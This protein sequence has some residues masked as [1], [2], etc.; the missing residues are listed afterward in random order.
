MQK[1][2]ILCLLFATINL[3]A[4][5]PKQV[6]TFPADTVKKAIDY[7]TKELS[8]NHPGFY[9]Y[10]SKQEFDH[11]IDSVKSSL[12]DSLT[13]LDS[14]LKLKPIISKIG[15][16]H[17]G[18][19]LPKGYAE[20]LNQ[21]SNLIPLQVY[22][23]GKKAVVIKNFSGNTA[24]LPK[25]QI[26][27]INGVK[28][29]TIISNLLPLIPSDGYNLTMKYRALYYQ[30]PLWYRLLDPAEEFDLV[31]HKNGIEREY[32]IEG[33]K[34]NDIAESGFLKEPI[35][36]KQ[37]E[38]SVVGNAAILTIHSFANSDIKRVNQNF[39][40]FIKDVFRII[41]RNNLS[42]L[43][44]DLRDNTGGSDGNAVYLTKYFFDTPF[45]YWNRIEVTE[46]IAKQ[47]K[48][49]PLKLFY[50]KPLKK[51]SVWLWQ[52]A[53][54]VN[55]FDFYQPQ[56][57]ARKN[58]KGNTY[59]LIN[60]FC[61]SSCADMAAIL[62]HYKKAVFVGQETGGGY[63]GNTSGMMP[64]MKVDAFDFTISVPL[65]KY[66]NQVDPLKNVGRGTIPDYGVDLTVTDI[67]ERKD[68]ELEFILELIKAKSK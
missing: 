51:D 17:T 64:E 42:N 31:I 44:I 8:L 60:G 2:V 41:K 54:H 36:Q 45:R 52:K 39:K 59:V 50:R 56:R 30:F 24:I 10:H 63:Q 49:F 55:E 26:V 37:L 15:C 19:S 5:P 13:L 32:S 43:I 47:I 38:F 18:I 61:M 16:L 46:S 21:E 7:I 33:K 23:V 6:K 20:E 40:P 53:R 11:F 1:L 48:G 57:P 28:I 62:A 34:F 22:V 65:Q 27:S 3:Q 12:P 35:L 66:F 68:R 25:D 67:L 4:Q 14:Y 29:E 58:F 9:R